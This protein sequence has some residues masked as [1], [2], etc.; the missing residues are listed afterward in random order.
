M[1]SLGSE[2]EY[3]ARRYMFIG[4][5]GEVPC[6]SGCGALKAEMIDVLVAD[7]DISSLL[8]QTLHAPDQL[9]EDDAEGDDEQAEATIPEQCPFFM[10]QQDPA[11]VHLKVIVKNFSQLI[12]ANQTRSGDLLMFSFPRCPDSVY[13][14]CAMLKNPHL[15]MLVKARVTD[16]EAE[17]ELTGGKPQIVAS[18]ELFLE[19]LG[20]FGN[21]E[22]FELMVEV[23][24]CQ[25]FLQDGQDMKANPVKQVCA[26]S[27]STQPLPAPKRPKVELPFGLKLPKKTRKAKAKKV[28]SKKP[29]GKTKICKEF[30]DLEIV[31]SENDASANDLNSDDDD[32]DSAQSEGSDEDINKESELVVPPSD[33]VASEENEFKAVAKEIERADILRADVAESIAL[34]QL[35]RPQSSFFSLSLGI[36]EKG[37]HG[38]AVSGRSRCLHCKNII[39]KGSP[40]FAWYY[41]RARP[42]GWLHA[43]C[44]VLHI[45]A[46]KD[47]AHFVTS[48][49]QRLTA[50]CQAKEAQSSSS[51]RSKA[52]DTELLSWARKIIDALQKRR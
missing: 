45:V 41:S 42:H 13:F 33:E 11:F 44:T 9:G 49:V 37:E 25:H 34:S 52:E 18:H 46:Q 31:D 10:C 7:K 23:W 20:D 40:R 21:Y 47:D 22:N 39:V 16:D 43:H 17:F 1:T 32:G 27:V 14:L 48:S 3:L 19:H 30:E 29:S 26:F 8:G 4:C 12:K 50:L 36:D 6:I 28:P 35:S 38:L 24:Q 15:Q 5:C 51:S 2:I